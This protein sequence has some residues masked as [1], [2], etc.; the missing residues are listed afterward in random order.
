MLLKNAFK[1]NKYIRYKKLYGNEALKTEI[2]REIGMVSATW[3]LRPARP[4]FCQALMD[5]RL[6]AK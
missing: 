2:N 5:M 3:R 4:R 1:L 6:D